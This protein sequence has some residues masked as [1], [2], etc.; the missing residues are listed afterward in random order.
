MRVGV[1][2]YG[3]GTILTGILNIA[4][5]TFDASHQPI[6]SSAKIFRANR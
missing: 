1:W 6:E 4:W 5:G 2:F 3:L